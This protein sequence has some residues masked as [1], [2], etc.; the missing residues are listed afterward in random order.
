MGDSHDQQDIIGNYYSIDD[1]E[2]RPDE[3]SWDGKFGV[4][5]IAAVESHS[6]ASRNQGTCEPPGW[7]SASS[8]AVKQ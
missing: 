3:V 2:E 8:K 4:E 1:I 5:A 6:A 7:L